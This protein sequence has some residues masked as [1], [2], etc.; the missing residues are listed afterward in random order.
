MGG[1]FASGLFAFDPADLRPGL[2]I[3]C[4]LLLCLEAGGLLRALTQFSHLAA[5]TITN[6]SA[7]AH[8]APTDH[9]DRKQYYGILALPISPFIHLFLRFPPQHVDDGHLLSPCRSDRELQRLCHPE[10]AVPEGP[11]GQDHHPE[12]RPSLHT[13]NHPKD[14]SL[15][16]GELHQHRMFT[17]ISLASV[18]VQNSCWVV[19]FCVV[20]NFVVKQRLCDSLYLC[21]L[22][23]VVLFICRS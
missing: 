15:G 20:C 11:E 2:L 23:V 16:S 18:P 10:S 21:V 17:V 14:P 3:P 1:G 13:H 6:G 5:D 4:C 8:M 22:I 7:T 19:F 12:G 9:A